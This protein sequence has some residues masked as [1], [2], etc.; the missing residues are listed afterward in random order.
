MV[1]TKLMKGLGLDLVFI[2]PELRLVSRTPDTKRFVSD[3]KQNNETGIDSLKKRRNTRYD[4][5]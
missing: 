3:D 2:F 1:G 5:I 4:T